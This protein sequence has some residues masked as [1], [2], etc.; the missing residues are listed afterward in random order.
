MDINSKRKYVVISIFILVGL[1]YLIRLFFLQVVD[2][3]YKNFATNN[4]LRKEVQYPARGLIYDRNGE[5]LVYNKAAYDLLATPREIQPFDTLE[6]CNLLEISIDEL[7]QKLKEAIEYS[8]YKASRIV[9]QISPEKYAVL[10]EQLFKMKGFYV[11][12]RTLRQYPKPMAAHVLGYVSEVS[13][14]TIGQ[15]PYYKPGDYIGASG[16]E[17]SYENE[18]RGKKGVKYFM[19]DVHNRP[20]G[21]FRNG[22]AD[23]TAVIGR[24]LTSSLDTR[25]QEYGELLLQ[26]KRGSIVVIDPST[27]EVL[28]MANLPS[29]DPN[30]LVGRERGANYSELA[31]N[32]LQPLF[33]RALMAEYPPGST[34]KM[35]N[36]LIALQ[37]GVITPHTR[38]Q[39]IGGYH[40]GSFTMGC[41]HDQSFDVVGSIAKSC[42]AY[43]AYAFRAILEN[44]KYG[45][46]KSTYDVKKAYNQWRDYLLKMGFGRSLATDFAYE[47]RGLVPSE[48]NYEQ[49]TFKGNR[50][51]ALQIISVAIGQGELG[52]TPLQLANYAAMIANRGYYYI[53]HIVKDVEGLGIDERFTKPVYVGI[54]RDHFIPVIQG[55]EE[56]MKAGGTGAMSYVPGITICGKTGT[57]QNPHGPNHS[58]FMAFAPK[59]NPRIAVSVYIENG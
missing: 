28:A 34:F 2:T 8:R 48:T 17:K 47:K 18:L 11:Q 38:Y 14:S 56:V 4:V 21:S 22:A 15:N 24:N 49:R 37:E 19:V 16:I 45:D 12:A 6:L 50:W 55:M 53:P 43:Y 57:V 27:G 41:H 33:V 13:R 46:E 54:D 7:R 35:A 59:D 5:L 26:N 42:N 20:Q 40:A 29:Y 9:T 1:A 44:P 25:M 39:C 23:T 31:K 36:A 58:V 10:Q 51:R 3:R 30:L 52:V 32:P